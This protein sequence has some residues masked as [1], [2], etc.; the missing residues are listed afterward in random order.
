MLLETGV[1]NGEASAAPIEASSQ[2]PPGIMNQ[3]HVVATN[4]GTRATKRRGRGRRRKRRIDR[5]SL[6]KYPLR[7]I[8]EPL[9]LVC[10]NRICHQPKHP[11]GGSW[12]G[13]RE[14][15]SN[16]QDGLAKWTRMHPH[17]HRQ[18]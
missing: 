12:R 16:L 5:Q 14:S 11:R 8:R 2:V 17:A 6:S 9:I 10:F 15:Y 13:R 1:G 3:L 4:E 18:E 7:F